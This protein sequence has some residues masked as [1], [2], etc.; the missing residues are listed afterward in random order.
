MSI[1]NFRVGQQVESLSYMQATT[2]L[3]DQTQISHPS[4]QNIYNNGLHLAGE[5]KGS[6][7]AHNQ[8]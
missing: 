2:S 6:S 3:V 5:V 4:P 8:C 7:E 1:N